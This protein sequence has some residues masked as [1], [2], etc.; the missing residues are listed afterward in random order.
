M[1]LAL[2]RGLPRRETIAFTT[3]LLDHPQVEVVLVD[4]P[5]HRDAMHLLEIRIDKRYSL[6]D[7]VSFLLMRQR[8]MTDALTTD[9]HF[10][11]EGLVRL[12]KT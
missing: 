11:Q 9:H 2:V 7:A 6:C 4:E 8:Q 1:I 5:L 12:L 10:E 3:A